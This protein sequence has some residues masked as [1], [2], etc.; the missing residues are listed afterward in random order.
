MV[1]KVYF[2]GACENTGT[3]SNPMGMGIVAFD[4]DGNVL[5]EKAETTEKLGTS[6]TAEWGA[7][8]HALNVCLELRQT[9][10]DIRFYIYGDSQLIVN[11]AN[12]VWQVKQPHLLPYKE[13]ADTLISEL[14]GAL[15][16]IS[17]V[18]RH[19]NQYA[20]NLSKEGIEK[21]KE[22]TKS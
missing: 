15:V 21:W 8:V 4:K 20:D 22:L 10:K 5:V 7:F 1:V 19:N 3:G 17:W 6:N 12:N 9:Y 18:R 16:S 13:L 11:Q 14:K 2:D